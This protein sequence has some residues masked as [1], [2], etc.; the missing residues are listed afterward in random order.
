MNAPINPEAAPTTIL[1][2]TWRYHQMFGIV[3]IS[4]L[5]CDLSA[6]HNIVVRARLVAGG[7]FRPRFGAWHEQYRGTSPREAWEIL[8]KNAA[9]AD[10][11]LER[12]TGQRPADF[13]AFA[14]LL[15]AA[16]DAETIDARIAARLTEA[17]R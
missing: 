15:D 16:L 6:D 17:Q 11:R 2:L 8:T 4:E 5:V 9:L 10:G 1:R 7:L 3:D 13:A 14:A 12:A